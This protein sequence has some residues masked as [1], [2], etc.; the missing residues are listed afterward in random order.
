MH[1][2]VVRNYE[3][4]HN[5]YSSSKTQKA[6]QRRSMEKDIDTYILNTFLKPVV[7]H[8][9]NRHELWFQQDRVTYQAANKIM[10]VQQ[11]MFCQ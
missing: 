10:D 3:R 4:P 5:C 9:H 7:I 8:L 11:G 6:L 1:S 2:C